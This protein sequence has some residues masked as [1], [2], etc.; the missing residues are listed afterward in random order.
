[1]WQL[2]LPEYKFRIKIQNDKQYIFDNQR[3][4]MV[5]LTPEEW[6]RQNFVEYLIQEKKYPASY[7]AIEKQINVNGLKKRC[8]AIVY[9]PDFQPIMIIELKAPTI[10]LTQTTFDQAAV[11]NSKLKVNHLIISNG[12]EHYA[13]KVDSE[14]SEYQ[15]YNSIPIYAELL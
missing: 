4:K 11:Y 8:D 7:I 12:I 14:K 9:S 15:F 10:Q 13:C 2:N 6:V 1:M 5:V 3:K